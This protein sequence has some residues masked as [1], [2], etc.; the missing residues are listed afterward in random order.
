MHGTFEQI[1]VRLA[2]MG[3]REQYGVPLALLKHG[4]LELFITDFWNWW[5][6]KLRKIS[7]LSKWEILVKSLSNFHPEIPQEKVV[8]FNWLGIMA[9][10][11]SLRARKRSNEAFNAHFLKYG[12][13]FCNVVN[14][15]PK[16][17]HNVFI[18][19]SSASLESIKM[20]KELGNLTILDQID[21]ARFDSQIVLE[22]RSLFPGWETNNLLYN[23]EYLERVEA[24]W[25]MADIIVVN[26]EFS[27]KALIYQGVS[28]QKISVI[29]IMYVNGHG[30]VRSRKYN[31]HKIKLNVLYLSTVNLRKGI[32]YLIQAASLLKNAPVTFTVVG[33]IEI[34]QEAMSQAP[35]N[36][37]FVGYKP[38]VHQWF[39]QADLFLFPTI[40][41]GFGRV[42]LE[43]MA[44]GLPVIATTN[45]ANVVTPEKDGFIVPIRDP[46]AIAAAINRFLENFQLLSYM[47]ENAREKVAAFGFEP[48]ST[49]WRKVIETT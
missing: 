20:E 29:P 42:Q 8:A 18:G 45:C 41:D 7:S 31:M 48:V 25:R 12:K 35:P 11:S 14:R 24:E 46:G 40:T 3:S 38:L 43:A 16:G 30:M 33:P 37:E 10:L 9:R 5:A 22:E 26:S 47:S 13:A 4:I 39:E 28:P 27:K 15:I 23:E 1:R 44:H 6:D 21:T 32:Q 49:S 19:F 34:T 2:Q 36:V 17:D